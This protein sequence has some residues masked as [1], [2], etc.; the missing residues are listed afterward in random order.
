MESASGLTNPNNALCNYFKSNLTKSSNVWNWRQHLLP[1]V[2]EHL[3]N[4]QNFYN[5]REHSSILVLWT[6]I[7]PEFCSHVIQMI[8]ALASFVSVFCF[9]LSKHRYISIAM[10]RTI[11]ANKNGLKLIGRVS[12]RIR[13]AI[14]RIRS[15]SNQKFIFCWWTETFSRITK[16]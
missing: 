9:Q 4:Y 15:L 3:T 10:F 8:G 5:R 1:L 6:C 11:G 13:V 14:F 7:K 16:L 12:E 2:L